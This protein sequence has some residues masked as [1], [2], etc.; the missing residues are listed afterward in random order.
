MEC[1]SLN[2][3]WLIKGNMPNGEPVGIKADVPCTVHS[4]MI[5][6]KIIDNLYLDKNADNWMWIE[7]KKWCFENEFQYT[8]SDDIKCIELEF[9]GLDTYCNVYL[10]S[11]LISF[12][13]SAHITYTFDVTSIIQ[14]G[15]NNL[16]IEFLPHWEQIK[17]IDH[18]VCGGV[19]CSDRHFVRR[20]QCTFGWDWVH[21]LVTMGIWR[22]VNLY[23]NRLVKIECLQAQLNGLTHMG[24]NMEFTLFTDVKKEYFP[25]TYKQFDKRHYSDSPM[26]EFTVFAP[27][28][29]I[30]WQNKK[31]IRERELSENITIANP[32]LWYPNGYG[33]RPLY[34]LSVKITDENGILLNSKSINF[35][36][37][38]FQIAEIPD[39]VG[40]KDYE[41]ATQK[42][43]QFAK[44][45]PEETDRVSFITI[46]NDV[47]VM[48]KGGN[49]VPADPF[50]GNVDS[51]K[52]EE[53][54]RIACD[55]GINMLRVWGGGYYE[56]DE[57]YSLCDKYGIMVQQDFMLACGTFPYDDEDLDYHSDANMHFVNQYRTECE[58]NVAR[59][60]YHPSIM[61]YN[62]DN[63]CRCNYNDNHINNARRLS[64]EVAY[65][66]VRK[67]DRT[68]RFF[69]SSPIRGSIFNT[70]SCGLFHATG[71]LDYYFNMFRHGDLKNYISDFSSVLARFSN[72]API[73]GAVSEFSARR[74]V[75]ED[76]FQLG[77]RDVFDYHTKNHP[78][79]EFKDFHFF[80]H[81]ELGAEKLFGK[82]ESASDRI[83]K[84]N[85]LGFEWTRVTM[86]TYRKSKWYT[87]GI[88]FW[89]YNDCWPALGWSMVDYYCNPKGSFY[90]MKKCCR[91]I[92]SS[93]ECKDG[94][95]IVNIS[96]DGVKNASG[97]GV[98]YLID[99]SG[100]IIKTHKFDVKS[101]AN[102][103]YIAF[104]DEC[105]EFKADGTT[106]YVCDIKTD[107]GSDRSFFL[108]VK[109]SDL[110]FE[111][112]NVEITKNENE[113]ILKS[114]KTAFYVMLD[115]E[116]KFE[117]N[118]IL[119]LPGEEKSISYQKTIY[120]ETDEIKLHWINQI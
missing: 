81:I 112:A 104:S 88:L 47:K 93:V 21:R 31:L 118:C 94:K 6:N 73:M 46:V 78:A 102:E 28:G 36:I 57:F 41:I 86:E 74:F 66:S 84:I 106:V 58:Q 60:C 22:N 53:L 56:S 44:S 42:H 52:L 105:S 30:I 67:Y 18:N 39:K 76:E 110:K 15:T 69:S 34:T 24:A 100:N 14:D 50:P 97:I 49:W 71:L 99:N 7:E 95:V 43:L 83:Y 101:T 103:S 114:D 55:S 91:P 79:D 89:M 4:A 2:K 72:E 19:F 98:L 116:M 45:E 85:L 75:S 3:D 40:S 35:G 111:K 5:E 12:C 109:P 63:E 68:R 26:A 92:S 32:E 108:G 113:V 77:K 54:I 64:L 23:T 33:E 80:D 62:G 29:N 61:W 27:D 96:N 59:I 115:G 65:P 20:M 17:D 82:F 10:N 1:L 51:Q 25:I 11:T 117:D 8:K 37:R 70:P 119:L 16:K 87:S 48:C 120:N 107:M 38:D 9:E 13:D 90:A